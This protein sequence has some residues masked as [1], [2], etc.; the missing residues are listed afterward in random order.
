MTVKGS[1][2]FRRS[3]VTD[4]QTGEK[5]RIS[6]DAPVEATA[7]IT[8]DL[9]TLHMRWGVNYAFR[10]VVTAFKINEVQ[11]DTLSDRIDAFVEYKPDPRW[12]FR[13]FGKNLSNSPAT[14]SRLISQGLRGS[15]GLDYREVRT[16]RS[17]RYFGAN[18]QW[19]FG[20]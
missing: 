19:V 2:L 8:H 1:G 20:S 11:R 4:P 16:L 17:G 5:R 15:S 6:D 10:T 7:S 9:R 14:R 18:V 13:I 12:T 3:R